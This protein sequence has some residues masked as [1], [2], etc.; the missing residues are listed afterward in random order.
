[1][2]SNS[3]YN[4]LPLIE[5]LKRLLDLAGRLKVLLK[6]MLESRYFIWLEQLL[7]I[8]LVSLLLPENCFNKEFCILATE[9]I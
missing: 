9:P 7:S 8:G 6:L 3:F 5:Q 2:V 1:M 4:E